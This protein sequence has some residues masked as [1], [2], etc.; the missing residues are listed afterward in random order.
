MTKEERVVMYKRL[1]DQH[2][3]D[4]V[5]GFLVDVIDGERHRSD[6]ERSGNRRVNTPDFVKVSSL[7]CVKA[8]MCLSVSGVS[9]KGASRYS[10]RVRLLYLSERPS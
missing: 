3:I 4:A 1:A 8:L 5:L 10:H 7:M 2:G 6:S 9:C